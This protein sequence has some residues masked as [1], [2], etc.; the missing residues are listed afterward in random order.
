MA[1][2]I[3]PVWGPDGVLAASGI[4]PQ[5]ILDK[6]APASSGRGRK[7]KQEITPSSET[8]FV[9]RELGGGPVS[10]SHDSG[11]KYIGTRAYYAGDDQTLDSL[12]KQAK[13]IAEKSEEY[14]NDP[15]FRNIHTP[16]DL[17]HFVF[18]K[19]KGFNKEED[20][21][22]CPSE[23]HIA[24]IEYSSRW[25]L[26]RVTFSNDGTMV[27]YSDVPQV[28]F[29]TLKDCGDKTDWGVDGKKHSLVGIKFWDYVRVRGS[30]HLNCYRMTRLGV[31]P[32]ASPSSRG[33]G[34]ASDAARG[35][36]N[37]DV[38]RVGA[39]G[40]SVEQGKAREAAAYRPFAFFGEEL[41]PKM[42]LEIKRA[43]G[44]NANREGTIAFELVHGNMDKAKDLAELFKKTFIDSGRTSPSTKNKLKEI[45]E[46]PRM[47][48]H[49]AL[50]GMERLMVSLGQWPLTQ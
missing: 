4:L 42:K 40:N 28:I 31:S 20:A 13:T 22:E 47:E 23:C 15:L 45:A 21:F 34:G 7:P 30:R 43:A 38:T 1:E 18:D 50:M 8:G 37:R 16:G 33:Y 29:D 24:F 6:G 49:E 17:V 39:D 2:N 36:A 9:T 25:M 27:V 48:S 11:V 10:Y 3:T 14:K 44:P 41:T 26:L 35:A 46:S 32:N 5:Y 12:V 19:S